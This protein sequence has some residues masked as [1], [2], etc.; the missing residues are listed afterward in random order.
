[1]LAC[2]SQMLAVR[3]PSVGHMRRP[4]VGHSVGLRSALHPG[5]IQL[6]LLKD[7]TVAE[8]ESVHMKRHALLMEHFSG[9]PLGASASSHAATAARRCPAIIC[10]VSLRNSSCCKKLEMDFVWSR[11]NLCALMPDTEK[12]GCQLCPGQSS[13]VAG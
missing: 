10:S 6:Y 7:R 3:R 8:P 11:K 4:R 12:H 13:D 1:M 9:T 5:H 2:D